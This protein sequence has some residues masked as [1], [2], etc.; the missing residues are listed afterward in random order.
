MTWWCFCQR[1][2]VVLHSTLRAL[3]LLCMMRCLGRSAECA[4]TPNCHSAFTPLSRSTLPLIHIA[5]PTT[6]GRV[7]STCLH[8][9]QPLDLHWCHRFWRQKM[10]L[11]AALVSSLLVPKDPGL[12]A[13]RCGSCCCCTGLLLAPKDVGLT[14]IVRLSLS[15]LFAS[16]SPSS[17]ETQPWKWFVGR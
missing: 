1:V 7:R 11:D 6:V 2:R 15:F 9:R 13:K 5:P 4:W 12:G 14:C 16:G 17:R 8:L 10:T 3:M